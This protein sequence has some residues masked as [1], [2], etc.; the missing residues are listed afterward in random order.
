MKKTPVSSARVIALS[1][2]HFVSTAGATIRG[3]R[4]EELRQCRGGLPVVLE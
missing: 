1:Q 2:K 3:I 4:E